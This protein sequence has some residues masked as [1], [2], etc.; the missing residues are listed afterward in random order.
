MQVKMQLVV[1]KL[2]IDN[3]LKV[4]DNIVLKIIQELIKRIFLFKC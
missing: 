1:E 4:V 2:Y 3:Y